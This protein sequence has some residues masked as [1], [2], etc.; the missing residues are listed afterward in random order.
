MLFFGRDPPRHAFED[1]VAGVLYRHVEIGTDFFR[2]SQCSD[3]FI[4]H[5][6]RVGVHQ[7]E[8]LDA[9]DLRQSPQQ[10]R[11]LLAA[12]EIEAVLCRVLCDKNQLAHGLFRQLLRLGHQLR[13]GRAAKSASNTR[14]GA[15]R[16]G[17]LAALGNFQIS[18]VFRRQQMAFAVQLS[19]CAQI[20]GH[21]ADNAVEITIAVQRIDL[22]NFAAQFFTI[23]LRETTGDDHLFYPAFLLHRHCVEDGFDGLFLRRLDETT[24]IDDDSLCLCSLIGKLD[25][26]CQQAAVQVFGIDQIFRA[27][28]GDQ[29]NFHANN[30]S[31]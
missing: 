17:V 12:I 19:P 10:R 2:L 29:F 11:K 23:T 16:A 5:M 25:S 3:Y 24:G 31:T 9:I 27:P 20:A 8:P 28:E 22:R 15:K 21:A 30:A 7:A 13:D 1:T 26:P 14:D 18:I 4:R 6:P